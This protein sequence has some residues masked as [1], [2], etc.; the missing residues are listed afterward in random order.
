MRSPKHIKKFE[1][2]PELEI[3]NGRYG[4]Y[5]YPYKGSNY[6][7][8]K[9]II[10][11]DLNLDACRGNHQ[12]AKRPRCTESQTRQIRQEEK[13]S[14]Q[15]KALSANCKEGF[16]YDKISRL[17]SVGNLNA[18]QS[19]SQ[20]YHLGYI[21][22]QGKTEYLHSLILLTQYAEIMIELVVFLH[23]VI[24]IVRNQR[25]AIILTCLFHKAV[26]K[27]ATICIRPSLFSL[28][29]IPAGS[30][31]GTVIPALS[32]YGERTGYGHTYTG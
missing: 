3:L 16:S 28:N 21:L 18:K 5:I 15:K 10:P 24:S 32:L 8:P 1:E 19:H 14:H 20:T 6:K 29:S 7:I 9:D 25:R 27:S 13:K 23:K 22:G 30:C 31:A 11:Q 26:A 12:T 17:H 2:E 4:P